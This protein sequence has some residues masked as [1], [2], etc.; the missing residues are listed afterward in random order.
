MAQIAR[1]GIA[2]TIDPCHTLHDGDVLFALSLGN[3]KGNFMSL[4]AVAPEVVSAAI[5]RAI[6]QAETMH[7]IPAAKDV[8]KW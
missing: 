8:I 5:V 6:L 2:R 1:A 4:S 7:G 3:N